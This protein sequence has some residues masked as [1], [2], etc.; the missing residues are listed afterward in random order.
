MFPSTEPAIV[1]P[2]KLFAMLDNPYDLNPFLAAY[3]AEFHGIGRVARI[4]AGFSGS[5][6]WRLENARGS[7]CLRR[8]PKE[9]P[10]AA[11]LRQIHEVLRGVFAAGFE[12]VPV[13]IATLNGE[14]F[15]AHDGYHWEISPWLAGEASLATV[16]SGA[17]SIDATMAALTALAEFHVAVVAAPKNQLPAAKAPGIVRRLSQLQGLQNGGLVELLQH[18]AA[19]REVWPE[20]AERGK[21]FIGHFQRLAAETEQ[22]LRQAEM[23]PGELTP[24]IR[25]IHREHVLFVGEQVSGIVDF[26]AIQLDNVAC[27]V[28]RLLGSIA[29]NNA[30]LWTVGL[31]A[32]S[33]IRAL[34]DSERLLV[35]TY[36]ES[37]ALLSGINWLRWVFVEQRE[38]V[39]RERVLARFDEIAARI[40]ER[41]DRKIVFPV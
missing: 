37:G 3:P 19:N 15:Y 22:L 20:L 7:F 17:A 25:D 9:H 13:P 35:R 2:E 4:S 11:Q 23:F 6:V 5:A 30:M 8:W 41:F 10:S 21:I 16:A 27:D 26:G 34:S 14:T 32:F 40:R 36:D 29:G 28:A 18:I 24:C 1:R 31:A 12:R 38:F 39:D 33:Q